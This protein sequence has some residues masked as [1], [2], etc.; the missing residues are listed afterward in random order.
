MVRINIINP[1]YLSDQHLIAEYLEIIMLVN[2]T[3]KHPKIK[4]AP[5]NYALGKGHIKFFKNRN[6]ILAFFHNPAAVGFTAAD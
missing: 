4:D 3:K 2:Y 5:K 1:K 6:I